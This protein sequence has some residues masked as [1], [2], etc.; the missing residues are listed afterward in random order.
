MGGSN[1][2]IEP[3]GTK[4]EPKGVQNQINQYKM[5]SHNPPKIDIDFDAEKGCN[6]KSMT[7]HP[8]GDSYQ[9]CR[10]CKTQSINSNDMPFYSRNLARIC[11]LFIKKLQA[12]IPRVLPVQP[13]GRSSLTKGSIP[14]DLESVWFC[15]APGSYH[16]CTT[17]THVTTG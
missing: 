15:R 2:K 10:C 17:C 12:K 8:L 11:N 6:M 4:M 7:C 14:H 5:H 1:T 16:R 13:S 3:E 9:F